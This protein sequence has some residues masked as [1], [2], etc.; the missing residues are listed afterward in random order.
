MTS[1]RFYSVELEQKIA[2]YREQ[3]TSQLNA[4]DIEDDTDDLSDDVVFLLDQEKALQ[5]KLLELKSVEL[6]ELT[7]DVRSVIT[8]HYDE[9]Q[10]SVDAQRSFIKSDYESRKQQAI[11]EH[12]N[13]V[14]EANQYNANLKT[15]YMQKHQELLAYKDSLKG[16]FQRYEISPLDMKIADTVT[17]DEFGT[18]VDAAVATCTQYQAKGDSKVS[19]I[20]EP[21]QGGD[22]LSFAIVYAVFLLIVLYFATPILTIPV[23]IMYFM[24]IHNMH[25][26]V[27][28][29]R[30]AYALMSEIDYGR[31]VG[32]DEY[33]TVEELDVSHFDSDMQEELACVQDVT[34]ERD[35]AM[36]ESIDDATEVAKECT[37]VRAEL[38]QLRE[39]KVHKISDILS[40]V[41][42]KINDIMENY[43]PFP[44]TITRSVVM[45]RRYTL[46]RLDNMLD[47]TVEVPRLNMVFDATNRDAAISNMKLYL[48][49]AL[50]SVRVQ[51]LLIDII[52]PVTLGADFVEFVTNES[53]DYIRIN[54]QDPSKLMKEVRDIAQTNV[55]S[56]G[57]LD[58]DAFNRRAEEQETPPKG[59]RLVIVVSGWEKYTDKPKNGGEDGKERLDFIEFMRYSADKGVMLWILDNKKYPN[60]IWVDGHY[61]EEGEALQYTVELG[62]T[63]IQ[64]FVTEL[65][66]FKDAGIPYDEKFGKKFIP[67][68]KWWTWDTIKGIYMPFGLEDGKP[69]RGLNVAL[70]LGDGNVHAIL[71][72][73]TGAGKSAEINQHI[74]SL[75]TMYPPS[76]LIAVYVDLKNVEAAK[77]TRGF[78]QLMS[79]WMSDEEEDDMRKKGEYYSRISR[80]PHLQLIAGTTD[81]EYALSIFE[82]LM[83]EM[84]RRQKVIDKAG[85]T[86][87]QELRERILAKYNTEKNG[88][89]KKGTWAEM[90]KDWE[91][92]KPNVYDIYGDLPRM[93]IIFDEFQVM[94]NPEFVPPRTIDSINGKIT[95][96]TKLARAM[97]CHFW[98]TSQS[99]KGTMSKDT[100]GN[101]S[102]RAALRCTADTSNELLGNGA[103]GTI[104]DKFGY[105]YTNDSAGEDKSKNR[106]W[107]VPFLHESKLHPNY[108]DIMN[109]MCEEFN[110]THRMAEFYDE[111][112][113]VPGRV[114][115]SWYES[116]PDVFCKSDT[117]ILG[118]RAMYSTNK[119]PITLQL[120]NDTGENIMI[121]AFEKEDML[122]LAMTVAYNIKKSDPSVPLLI[123]CVDK[124]NYALMGVDE[125]CDE[126]FVSLSQP[127]Q[128][129]P[130][131]IEALDAVV[132]GREKKDPPYSM[133]YVMLINWERADSISVS[134]KMKVQDK[135][136]ELLRRGPLVGA[137]FIMVS[138][139]KLEMPK[140]IP[141]AC[142]HKV[143]GLLV[144]SSITFFTDNSKVEKL[145]SKESG[146]GLFAL[147][148]YGTQ[149]R[150]FRIY[151]HEFKAEIKSRD[152]VL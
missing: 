95:A 90:R 133:F 72:G 84:S 9:L 44:T 19:K 100:M 36:Q 28:K 106:F 61:S 103:A 2:A 88:N 114:F 68:E 73:A 35:A 70:S 43:H 48:T 63:A 4:F 10:A 52:D 128:D 21:L 25:K 1:E 141:N 45:Q 94:F 33:Q 54:G 113:L 105:M 37:S 129:I 91:W 32:D 104:T 93:L 139:E 130:T 149:E 143:C 145:P 51:K 29:L 6:P 40:K 138:K 152:V 116:H 123:H 60:T 24:S 126:R 3:Y 57:K 118:E 112:I 13:R 38:V 147:Y 142:A 42:D 41:Q 59:Y 20:L 27:E 79:N 74:I 110:E 119:A 78:D 140:L 39:E 55:M 117:F 85:V 23:F 96:I 53:K 7:Y 65:A 111:K 122:N 34:D 87:I 17:A 151:Q 66:E 108:I 107:R 76:E 135:F 77:F 146:K 102:L 67:R 136:K 132:T 127:T 50:L 131:L 101:F 30:L 89:A 11:T 16:V 49:N 64:T 86:K 14:S 5:A 109:E 92:Y 124:D 58:I 98:F 69:D 18:L 82:Y 134:I 148:N 71:G 115:H 137:H 125:F 120:T 121:A 62:E 80:I 144:G 150:K 81:G 22:N 99:M 47:I 12:Q 46:G 75:F 8:A 26:D 56:L 31:F 83:E 97:G 15:P